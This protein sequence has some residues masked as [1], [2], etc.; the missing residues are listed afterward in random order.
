MPTPPPTHT[1]A[2]PPRPRPLARPLPPRRAVEQA[3]Q[4]LSALMASAAAMVALAEKFRGVQAA[5]GGGA[6]G[7]GDDD[8]M[9][10]RWAPLSHSSSSSRGGGA[11]QNGGPLVLVLELALPC[12]GLE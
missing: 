3:F 8:L 7:G 5:D 10:D 4:D 12:H 11:S 2:L 9:I 1:H 6:A